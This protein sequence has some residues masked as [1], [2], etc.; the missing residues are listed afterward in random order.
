[1]LTAFPLYMRDRYSGMGEGKFG[2][3]LAVSLGCLIPGALL[4]AAGSAASAG[5]A[6]ATGSA[7]AAGPAVAG[8]AAA[9]RTTLRGALSSLD[10]AVLSY[11]AACGLSWLFA[12]DRQAAWTGVTGWSMGL[13]SQ[14]L[15]GL[16]YFLVSRHFPLSGRLP[17][18]KIILAGHFLASGAVFLLGL[19]H[20][21]SIDP[22]G[23]YEG[24]DESWR[25]L[26][27]ST[28]GQAS[29]YSSYV[30]TVLVIGVTLFFVLEDGWKRTAVGAYCALGFGTVVT[31]N[32]DSAFAAMAML[33]FGLLLVACDSLERMERF[34]ETVL[35][36]LGSF[37][38][39][40]LLQTAFPEYAVGLG[41]VSEFFSQSLAVW[42]LFLAACVACILLELYRQRQ[43]NRSRI[44]NGSRLRR[45]I[46]GTAAVCAAGYL[47]LLWANTSG[48]L[49]RWFHFSSENQYLLFDKNWGNSR[50]FSWSFTVRTFGELPFF[51]K[52]VG[53]G[54]DSFS[55]YCYA[56][57]ELAG[58]LNHFF[59]QNQTLTNA[60][61]EFLNTLF[62]L[63]IAGLV[64]FAAMF[65]AAMLR[66]GRLW[67]KAPF[68]LAGMLAAMVYAAHNFFCYQQVCCTPFLFLILGLAERKLRAKLLQNTS[69]G[70]T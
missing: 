35:L 33:L 37:L 39:V 16:S 53:V 18:E 8:S 27:L 67:Q 66:F 15:F 25:L 43:G 24:L 17:W 60:H 47:L 70:D 34:L 65:A 7:A 3:F 14:L 46:A 55:V 45:G 62:C 1:M 6:A 54:P 11:L 32:S 68:S 2:F 21:F 63:G 13:R 30:C 52:L 9:G 58:E 12:V 61:N 29:W 50:G 51:R 59:G 64:C 10:W 23:I 20:R 57:P 31:Q 22:L 38:A 56:D 36:M 69:L 28:I 19:L 4:A 5:S 44:P 26:F 41:G 49:E 48:L 42:A 40:G